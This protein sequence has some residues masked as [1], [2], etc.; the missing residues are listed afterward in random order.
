MP[1]ADGSGTM[2]GNFIREVHPSGV[3]AAETGVK[4]EV[5]HRPTDSALQR[6]A[7]MPELD[8]DLPF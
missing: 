5:V 7:Q 4:A 6:N 2:D 1:K 8:N 3:L